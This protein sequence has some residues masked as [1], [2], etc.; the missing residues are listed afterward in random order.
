MPDV[1]HLPKVIFVN[2]TIHLDEQQHI[3]MVTHPFSPFYGVLFTFVKRM[4][5]NGKNRL[6]CMDE[7]GNIRVFITSWTNYPTNNLYSTLVKDAGLQNV[8]FRFEDLDM[9]S[10]LLSSIKKV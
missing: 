9:L 4:I 5:K 7:A 10:K 1:G 8:D 2:A 6:V 3:V